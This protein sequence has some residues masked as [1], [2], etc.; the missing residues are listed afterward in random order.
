MEP[1]DTLGLP[2][3][4]ECPGMLG[5][6]VSVLGAIV[7]ILWLIIYSGGVWSFALIALSGLLGWVSFM[8]CGVWEQSLPRP[9]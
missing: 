4:E 6:I 5:L 1:F 9:T 8:Y 3:P 7:G 2:S